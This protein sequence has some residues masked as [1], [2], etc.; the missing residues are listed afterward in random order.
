MF[1]GIGNAIDKRE[2]I[3]EEFK[4]IDLGEGFEIA[5]KQLDYVPKYIECFKKEDDQKQ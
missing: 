1:C 2:L 3:P 5:D 4:D